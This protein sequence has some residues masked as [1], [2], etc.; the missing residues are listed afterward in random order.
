[1]AK[2]ATT[3]SDLSYLLRQ[4]CNLRRQGIAHSD[5]IAQL[6]PVVQTMPASR[7]SAWQKIAKPELEQ[8]S[9]N[10]NKDDSVFGFAAA[11]HIDDEDVPQ[12]L[13]AWR[14][15]LT[16]VDQNLTLSFGALYT[17][18]A[19]L[20]YLMFIL[21]VVVIIYSTKVLPSFLRTFENLSASLPDFTEFFIGLVTGPGI[22]VVFAILVLMSSPLFAL[23][24]LNSRVSD[25][26]PAP[27]WL[28][29]VPIAERVAAKYHELLLLLTVCIRHS[30]KTEQGLKQS[31][32]ESAGHFGC[33]NIVL[34]KARK[35]ALQHSEQLGTLAEEADYQFDSG[36]QE[37]LVHCE[38][39]QMASGLLVQMTIFVLVGLLVVA[40]YLPIFALGTVV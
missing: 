7:M 21:V 33:K 25:L 28:S 22:L 37:F 30:A 35:H 12:V 13:E 16:S 23:M 34:G 36:V 32:D 19:Y 9:D 17:R 8:E 27:K 5:A 10:A 29:H 6:D 15:M 2:I 14:R 20:S 11:Q 38:K 26:R 4:Y 24:Y 40:M 18:V 3:L 31:L 1:M 39:A